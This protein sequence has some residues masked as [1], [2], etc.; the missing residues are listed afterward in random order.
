MAGGCFAVFFLLAACSDYLVGGAPPPAPRL[1]DVP[2]RLPLP[3]PVGTIFELQ[4]G[5]H[6]KA[7]ASAT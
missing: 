6:T 1:A 7:F 5:A 4:A 2:V 3:L